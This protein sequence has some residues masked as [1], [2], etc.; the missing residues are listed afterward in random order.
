MNSIG[1]AAFQAWL[2]TA[3]K[4]TDRN[5][6]RRNLPALRARFEQNPGVELEALPEP[7]Q[8]PRDRYEEL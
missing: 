5:W 1:E 3:V 7:D 8:R 6:V 4:T 2:K